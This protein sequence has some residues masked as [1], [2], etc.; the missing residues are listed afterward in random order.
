[1]VI[2]LML[3]A[4]ACVLVLAHELGHVLLTHAMG[5]R[6]L[7]IEFRGFMLGVRLSVTS[8]SLRQVAWTLIAGPLAEALV[9]FIAALIWPEHLRW[10]LVLLSVQWTLNLIPWGLIPND[11]TRLL[12]LWLYGTTESPGGR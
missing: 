12:R 8:L 9:T 3:L 2:T 7:G 6:W 1:M 11:G 4:M 5:G 10:W